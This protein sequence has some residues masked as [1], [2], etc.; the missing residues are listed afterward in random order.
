QKGVERIM[1]HHL[2][3]DLANE[4]LGML[5]ALN[6]AGR[7]T[8]AVI[9]EQLRAA[10]RTA[11]RAKRPLTLD[12]VRGQIAVEDNRS[13]ETLRR[14]AT[15]EAGHAVVGTLLETG[16]LKSVSLYRTETAGGATHFDDG[17]GVLVTRDGFER[18]VMS[19]LAGRAAEETMLGEASQGAGGS[20]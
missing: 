20:E 6:A 18:T 5:T 12:D 9:E 16:T 13:P 2:G 4:D 19:L 10:R 11:R 1:R 17:T 15:H 14:S 8:G 3:D 7:A